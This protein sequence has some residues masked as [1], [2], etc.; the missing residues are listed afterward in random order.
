MTQQKRQWYIISHNRNSNILSH[1]PF[2][3]KETT[4]VSIHPNPLLHHITSS[5]ISIHPSITLTSNFTSPHQ[6]IPISYQHAASQGDRQTKN[7]NHEGENDRIK[8]STTAQQQLHPPTSKPASK[9][10]SQ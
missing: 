7:S 5:L 2:Q 8:H 4:D 10:K 3:R 9:Q 1:L 6:R